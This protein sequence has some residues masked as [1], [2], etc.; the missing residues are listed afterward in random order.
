MFQEVKN[1]LAANAPTIAIYV[2]YDKAYDRV[3]HMDL[4][5]KFFRL[6]IPIN[7]LKML[8]SWLADRTA[9]VNYG[10]KKSKMINVR[11]GLPQ[12][13]SLSPFSLWFTTVTSRNVLEPTRITSLQMT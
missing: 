3:W 8:E 5:V 11:I 4:L 12:E 2:D 6:G 1:N 9:Y 13:S 7:L 10:P